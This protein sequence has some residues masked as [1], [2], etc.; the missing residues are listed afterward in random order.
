[1]SQFAPPVLTLEVERCPDGVAVVHCHGK[2]VAGVTEVLLSGVRPLLVDCR[3]VVLD[4][5][6]LK[7]T[8]SMGLGALVRL[9]VS[10]KSSGCSLE[11]THLSQQ[12]RNLLG[13]THLLDVFVVI[14]ENR[15]R[16]M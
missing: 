3:R 14:G 11:L 5:S 9:Y 4:L 2:L 10:A 15:V 7:H 6:D 1:M 16:M 12:I 8:D 13:L